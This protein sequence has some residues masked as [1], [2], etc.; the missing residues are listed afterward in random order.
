MLRQFTRRGV[1]RRV[2][3]WGVCFAMRSSW[4]ELKQFN[5]GDPER[6]RI[7]DSLPN[8]KIRCDSFPLKCPH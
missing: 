4:A 3:Y 6:D 2:E 7:S 8:G 1:I 5:L